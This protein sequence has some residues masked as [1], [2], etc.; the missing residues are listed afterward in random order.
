MANF[1]KNLKAN[2]TLSAII[3]VIIGIVL[4]IWPG[5]ST[6]VVCMVLGGI[7]LVYGIIQIILY[8]LARERTLYLQ[9]MLILGI[10]FSVLGAWILL[11]PEGIIATVPIIIGI[12]I[13]IHGLHNAI[14]AVDLKKLG[15]ENWWA[16]L[17]FGILTIV[18]GAVLVYNPFG[19]VE[20]VV[21]VIGAFLVYDGLSDMWILS[22]LFKTKKN[23][24]KIIDAEATIIDED[25]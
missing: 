14:Q 3:C 20:I 15:Y 24:E 5:T 18:L 16:A 8:L 22:R 17:F 2:Y 19:A 11:K 23:A 25:K 6:Q 1:F 13:I 21:R 4:I 7:L 12:I 9:G 10:I